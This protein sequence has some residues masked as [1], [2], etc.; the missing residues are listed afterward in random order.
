MLRLQGLS[1][2]LT[3]PAR[4]AAATASAR[5]LQGDNATLVKPANLVAN[6]FAVSSHR[7]ATAA[8]VPGCSFAGP[9]R[10][11]LP[12]DDPL[13][14]QSSH[15]LPC[16]RQVAAAAALLTKPAPAVAV[17]TA[18]ANASISTMGVVQPASQK[19]RLFVGLNCRSRL[20]RPVHIRVI[21]TPRN[22]RPITYNPLLWSSWGGQSWNFGDFW[23]GTRLTVTVQ[24]FQCPRGCDW[25]RPWSSPTTTITAQ[26]QSYAYWP[27]C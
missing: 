4:P 27:G 12:M 17:A 8:V 25:R 2:D 20:A 3:R 6:P 21:I 19:M 7:A 23:W 5:S 18:T 22:A 13:C 14:H 26:G 15:K 24:I 9:A 16:S 10:L 1:V 11:Q